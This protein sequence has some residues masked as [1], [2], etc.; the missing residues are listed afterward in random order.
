MR[1]L[2]IDAGEKYLMKGIP[3]FSPETEIEVEEDILNFFFEEGYSSL[4][5]PCW[6]CLLHRI[7]RK[8][9]T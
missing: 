1:K 9:G 4:D 3:C 6:V 7:I 8:G 5:T 2:L